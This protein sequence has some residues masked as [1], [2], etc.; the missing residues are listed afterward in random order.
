MSTLSSQTQSIASGGGG[1]SHSESSQTINMRHHYLPIEPPS[2]L[3]TAVRALKGSLPILTPPSNARTKGPFKPRSTR[4]TSSYQL[5][6]FAE[7]TLGSGSL[8]KAVKLPEGEDINEWL[9]V[10][11]IILSLRIGQGIFVAD[12]II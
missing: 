2:Y 6:K 9:A 5:R 1:L 7:E 3:S 4:G 11:G 8:R 10:N 12:L